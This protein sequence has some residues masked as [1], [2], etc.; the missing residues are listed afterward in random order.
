MQLTDM[1]NIGAAL[2]AELIRAG[3]PTPEELKRLGVKEAF[4]RLRMQVPD[5]C[6]NRL[7]ALAGAV[8]GVRWHHLP[9]ETKDEWKRWYKSIG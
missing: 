6:L 3:I 7:Y 1:P 5:A 9:Q 4:I 2:S 8:E